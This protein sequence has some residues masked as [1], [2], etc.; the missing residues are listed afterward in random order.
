MKNCKIPFD[1]LCVDESIDSYEKLKK[2]V[3]GYC[4]SKNLEELKRY[5]NENWTDY[6]RRLELE[7]GDKNIK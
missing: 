7:A 4:I 1:K 2:I 3:M 6:T 5:K